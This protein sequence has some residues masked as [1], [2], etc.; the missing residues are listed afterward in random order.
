MYVSFLLF[1]KYVCVCLFESSVKIRRRPLKIIK[2]EEEVEKKVLFVEEW[3]TP[4]EFNLKAF[5]TDTYEHEA[6][7]DDEVVLQPEFAAHF[8]EETF[9][10]VDG[11]ESK[12]VSMNEIP[13]DMNLVSETEMQEIKIVLDVK[14]LSF[15]Y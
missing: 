7:G 8:E 3:S 10:L 13:E 5:M 1:S 9:M 14:L 11:P 12:I 2:Q 6:K 15:Y 4:K